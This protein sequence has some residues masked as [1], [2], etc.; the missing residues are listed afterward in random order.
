MTM[1]LN[2]Y[3]DAA[4]DFARPARPMTADEAQLLNWALG[5]AGEAGEFAEKVKKALF[6]GHP[7]SVAEMSKELGDVLWYAANAVDGINTLWDSKLTLEA[8]ANQNLAKLGVRYAGGFSEEKSRA[9]VDVAPPA[10]T[11]VSCNAESCAEWCERDGAECA[12]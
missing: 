2:G 4:S 9:R 8:V 10:E 12:A 6:H 5:L 7:V 3:A 11:C 1:T